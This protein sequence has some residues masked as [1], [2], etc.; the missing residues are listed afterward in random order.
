MMEFCRCTLATIDLFMVGQ[1]C[2]DCGKTRP[3]P[4]GITLDDIAKQEP[5]FVRKVEGERLRR[6]L[7]AEGRYVRKRGLA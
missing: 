4:R 7:M 3:P 5:I 6:K 2:P 1:A